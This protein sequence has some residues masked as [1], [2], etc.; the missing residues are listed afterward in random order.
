MQL[1]LVELE[2]L[3]PSEIMAAKLIKL[4]RVYP[5]FEL[6]YR[7]KM[8]TALA[9]VGQ[10]NNIQTLG[11]LAEFAYADLQILFAKSTNLAKRLC[12]KT[13]VITKLD[14]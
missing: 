1:G 10:I 5:M 2:I 9:R 7:E 4:P 11:S 12:D 13:P 3:S 14:I 6:G 8:N